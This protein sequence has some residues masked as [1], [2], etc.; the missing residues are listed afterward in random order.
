MN[1]L[2]RVTKITG[3]L[4]VFGGLYSNLEATEAILAETRRRAVSMCRRRR[5]ASTACQRAMLLR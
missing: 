3:P 5:C 1:D 2:P 4:L